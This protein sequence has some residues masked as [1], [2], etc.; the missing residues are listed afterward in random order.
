MLSLKDKNQSSHPALSPQSQENR[1]INLAVNLAE[2]QLMDGTAKSQVIVHFLKLG[3]EQ[4][5]LEKERLRRENVLLEAKTRSFDTMAHAE[6]LY[7]NAI[8]AFK[9]YSGNG[10][11]DN[12]QEL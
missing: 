6:E 7:N 3:T 4:A 1:M 9:T 2:K 11:E 10:G 8:R 12:D 5:A